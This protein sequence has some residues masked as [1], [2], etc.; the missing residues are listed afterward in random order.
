MIYHV[1][2][3]SDWQKAQSNGYFEVES[4]QKEGFIHMSLHDQVAGVLS[5]YYTN[6]PEK[7]LLLHVDESKLTAPLQYDFSESMQQ[8]FPH[9][10]GKLNLDAVVKVE[11]IVG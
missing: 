1:S 6:C 9:I 7:L 8:E 3:T 11:E 4:L 5:R 10:Y 2:T